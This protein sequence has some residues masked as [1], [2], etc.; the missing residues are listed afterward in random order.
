VFSF[1]Q[2]FLEDRVYPG[3]TWRHQ[4]LPLIQRAPTQESKS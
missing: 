3:Q 2:T 1:A 4:W